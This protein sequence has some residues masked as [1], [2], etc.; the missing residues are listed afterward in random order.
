MRKVTLAAT[1]FACGPDSKANVDRAEALAR[2]A[3]AKGAEIVLLQELFETPY[4]CKDQ[5][6]AHF[7]LAKPAM[8]HPTLARMAALARELGVVLPVSFF[9]RAN[10]AYYNSV[11]IIEADGKELGIYRKSH[12]PDGVGYQ[13][14]FYFNPVD[15]GFKAWSTANGRSCPGPDHGV[16]NRWRWDKAA[17]LH[18]ATPCCARI[19]ETTDPSRCRRRSGHGR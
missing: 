10:N 14:K 5:L 17:L 8:A 6:Q 9:E 3:A 19:R 1:Q 2:Q 13:E 18:P 7:A 16:L 15:T 11:A 4:F 12:I